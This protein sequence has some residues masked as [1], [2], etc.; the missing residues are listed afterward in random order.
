[1]EKEALELIQSNQ[2]TTTFNI[3]Q[4]RGGQPQ[5]DH[6]EVKQRTPQ[7]I[8]D[9]AGQGQGQGYSHIVDV[10]TRPDSISF[11]HV[12]ICSSKESSPASLLSSSSSLEEVQESTSTLVAARALIKA[13]RTDDAWSYLRS[14]FAMQG[15]N[16]FMP[17]YIY[18]NNQHHDNHTH[19]TNMDEDGDYSYYYNGTQIPKARLFPSAN[20]LPK[21]YT[22]C[23]SS[24][25]QHTHTYTYQHQNQYQ[26]QYAQTPTSMSCLDIN[27]S[28]TYTQEL[29]IST[30][31][32]LSALPCTLQV[33]SNYSI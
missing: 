22:S 26:Y 25:D 17:K 19:S 21:R 16:G 12:A 33:C 28:Y 1:V 3:S 8:S 14:L 18:W 29:N 27:D 7:E 31:G 11:T 5:H 13:N 10:D 30:S 32:R 20:T 24:L 4:F 15:T 9:R 23:P 2:I 6:D